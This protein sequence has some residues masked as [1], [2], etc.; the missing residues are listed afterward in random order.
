MFFPTVILD[1]TKKLVHFGEWNC[2]NLQAQVE[3][4]YLKKFMC[5]CKVPCSNTHKCMYVHTVIHQQVLSHLLGYV[6]LHL[7][8]AKCTYDSRMFPSI[9]V[10]WEKMKWS[11]VS[12]KWDIAGIRTWDNTILFQ[13]EF[14][15]LSFRGHWWCQCWASVVSD[16]VWWPDREDLPQLIKIRNLRASWRKFY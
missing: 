8:I 16:N 6:L 9:D 14:V 15:L 13:E 5:P 10:T 12:Q 4:L 2:F 11:Q 3:V 1:V 7:W